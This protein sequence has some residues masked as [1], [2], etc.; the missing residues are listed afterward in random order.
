MVGICVSATR[1]LFQSSPLKNP[2]W[3]QLWFTMSPFQDSKISTS[4]SVGHTKG[5]WGRS[6][7]AGQMPD[8]QG[9]W[10]VTD[11]KPFGRDSVWCDVRRALV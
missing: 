5:S 10:T 7:N 9:A 6:Q 3:R 2:Q 8:A 1:C 4:P 11:K